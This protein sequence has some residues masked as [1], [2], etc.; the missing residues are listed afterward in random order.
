MTLKTIEL[1]QPVEANDVRALDDIPGYNENEADPREKHNKGLIRFASKFIKAEKD[2]KKIGKEGGLSEDEIKNKIDE[3]RKQRPEIGS[4]LYQTIYIDL[5]NKPADEMRAKAQKIMSQEIIDEE[6]LEKMP[7]QF[8]CEG[9]FKGTNRP[10]EWPKEKIEL[11]TI[12]KIIDFAKERTAD[13]ITF[14]GHGEPMLD[15]IFWDVVN[16]AKEKG[17]KTITF[18]Q[19]LAVKDLETAKRLLQAGPVIIKRNFDYDEFDDFQDELVGLG[20]KKIKRD[21]QIYRASQ[22]M[23]MGRKLLCEAR[24]ELGDPEG[25]EHIIAVDSYITKKNIHAL[26]ALLRFCRNNNLQPYFEAFIEEG[27]PD[28][29]RDELSVSEK[30]L[31]ELFSKLASIDS[32]E[33]GIA[34]EIL[35]KS[36][37]YGKPP[38]G[39]SDASLNFRPSREEKGRPEVYSCIS[40]TKNKIGDLDIEDIEESLVQLTNPYHVATTQANKCSGCSK[41]CPAAK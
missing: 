16:Y 7:C 18:T 17:L 26:P 1:N 27:Q 5:F 12:K 30:E 41:K 24:K 22:L 9:C 10:D 29:V 20:G 36:R 6:D 8:A 28:K 23:E 37:V 38:C 15:P 32:E 14:A 21:G 3:L 25:K 4:L 31:E 39:K 2:I 40:T 33:F 13:T 11:E 19:T 34:I 35:K